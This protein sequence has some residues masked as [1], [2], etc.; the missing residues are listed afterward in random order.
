MADPGRRRRY[1][2]EAGISLLETVV[3]LGLFAISAATMGSFLV[4]QIRFATTNYLYTQAY[5][6][7][8]RQLEATRAL[9]YDAMAADSKAI[10]IGGTRYTVQTQVVNNSPE[11]GMKRITVDVGWKEPLGTRNVSVYTVYTEVQRN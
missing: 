3:A 2:G 6:L 1:T 9:R 11:T 5:S 7:A 10:T 8:E 4:Q